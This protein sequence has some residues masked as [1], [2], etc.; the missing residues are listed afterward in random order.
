MPQPIDF[1]TE[2]TRVT[3]VERLQQ[4]ADRQ[5]LNAQQRLA[6]EIE[7]QRARAESQV[8]QTNPKSGEVEPELKRKNPYMG[9]RRK[10]SAKDSEHKPDDANQDKPKPPLDENPPGGHS[11]DVTV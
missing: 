5:G 2:L 8:E 10:K 11:L 7:E 3:A 9:R 1:Q 4:Y 6:Q